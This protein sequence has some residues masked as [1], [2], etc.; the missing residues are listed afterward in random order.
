MGLF[1]GMG[2]G[3]GYNHSS[4]RGFMR[5][6][7]IT[8]SG[9]KPLTKAEASGKAAGTLISLILGAAILLN[10]NLANR[11]YDAT[12]R[13][14]DKIVDCGF[15]GINKIADYSFESI[16]NIGDSSLKNADKIFGKFE[17]LMNKV[18]I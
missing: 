4:S 14:H 7:Y 13:E 2:F 9:T 3:D 15:E 18:G 1:D 12:V 17:R 11:M 6:D 8:G 16:I 10:P 5:S